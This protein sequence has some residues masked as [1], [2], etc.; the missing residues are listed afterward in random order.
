METT[1]LGDLQRRTDMSEN[2]RRHHENQIERQVVEKEKEQR[3]FELKHADVKEKF[4][5]EKQQIGMWLKKKRNL[6]RKFQF[7]EEEDRDRMARELRKEEEL[8]R[9][10]QKMM[11]DSEFRLKSTLEASENEIRDISEFFIGKIRE[12]E[13][14]LMAVSELIFFRTIKKGVF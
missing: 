2:E 13:N 6:E 9:L 3:D 7:S 11:E 5:N 1:Y 14:E 8:I 4:D 10:S 12:T